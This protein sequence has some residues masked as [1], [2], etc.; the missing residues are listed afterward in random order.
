MGQQRLSRGSMG[1]SL[2]ALLLIV[3]AIMGLAGL[4]SP[5]LAA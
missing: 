5:R 3:T 4:A 2:I 1:R